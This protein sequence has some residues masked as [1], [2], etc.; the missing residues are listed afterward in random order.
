M[1]DRYHRTVEETQDLDL[2]PVMNLFM[3]LIPFLLMGAAFFHIGAIPVSLPNHTPSESDTPTTDTTVTL[4]MTIDTDK[5]ALSASSSGVDPD[6]LETLGLELPMG[7]SAGGVDLKKLQA[8][9]R[10]VKAGYPKSDTVI[11]LPHADLNYA[12]LVAILDASREFEAGRDDKGD[13]RYA[14]LFPKVVFSRL[15]KE[16]TASPEAP[17]AAAALPEASP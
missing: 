7:A 10:R 5:L 8:H 2:L 3:V 6:T 17:A 4:N 13:P 16:D 11:V 1:F 12:Q 15:L 14:P 9:L